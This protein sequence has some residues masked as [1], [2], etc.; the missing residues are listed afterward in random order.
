LFDTAV[1]SCHVGYA[2]PEREIYE[3][4]LKRLSLAPAD[5]VLVADGAMDELKGAKSVGLS[6]IMVTGLVKHLPPQSM[7]KRRQYADF[8]IESLG[9]LVAG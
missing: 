7:E 8:V 4:A 2:K 5:A 9:D 3:I 1:F 6:T